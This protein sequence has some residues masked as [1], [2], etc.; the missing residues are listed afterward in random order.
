MQSVGGVHRRCCD[1]TRPNPLSLRAP[2]PQVSHRLG[3]A[4]AAT[5][6]AADAEVYTGDTP[7]TVYG[8]RGE[9]EKVRRPQTANVAVSCSN[10]PSRS[11]KTLQALPPRFKH[12]HVLFSLPLCVEYATL[13]SQ[14]SE[15][16]VAV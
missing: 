4:R 15:P 3:V 13:R 9:V 12:T 16:T 11:P 2:R 14:H 5:D 7:G 6:A 10:K 1:A 8:D